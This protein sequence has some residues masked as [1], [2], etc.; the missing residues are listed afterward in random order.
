MS[1]PCCCGYEPPTPPNCFAC[2]LGSFTQITNVYAAVTGFT[3]RYACD[4]ASHVNRTVAHTL[5]EPGAGQPCFDSMVATHAANQ[6]IDDDITIISTA[7]P[8]AAYTVFPSFSCE[9]YNPCPEGCPEEFLSFQ[10][11][12]LYIIYTITVADLGGTSRINYTIEHNVIGTQ[13]VAGR[14]CHEAVPESRA[15][16]SGFAFFDN[17]QMCS[18]ID[19]D[20]PITNGPNLN[21]QNNPGLGPSQPWELTCG[22]PLDWS[23]ANVNIT[24][25][26]T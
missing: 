5:T 10:C 9:C 17:D 16:Y 2:D 26:L 13:Y 4:V 19:V 21:P 20:I 23:S 7:A 3:D 25:N 18:S 14:G 8:A 11:C 22:S 15:V 6:C 1:H 12:E 24:L